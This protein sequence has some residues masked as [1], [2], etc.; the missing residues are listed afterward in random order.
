[1]SPGEISNLL[2]PPL[3]LV[4]EI[5]RPTPR[6]SAQ[7][8]RRI[9]QQHLRE[10]IPAGGFFHLRLRGGVGGAVR[11]GVELREHVVRVADEFVHEE[12]GGVGEG[13][14]QEGVGF[15]GSIWD[16]VVGWMWD[17]GMV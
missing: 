10:R 13:G 7:F 2:R 8:P 1:M 16:L 4:P 3:H 12:D 9:V 5:H 11:G 17:W 6:N 14:L 15:E